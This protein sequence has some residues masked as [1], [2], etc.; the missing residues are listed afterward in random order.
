MVVGKVH[1]HHIGKVLHS[2]LIGTL[3]L[4]MHSFNKAG[5]VSFYVLSVQFLCWSVVM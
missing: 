2:C 4:V 3:N 1:G 5:M